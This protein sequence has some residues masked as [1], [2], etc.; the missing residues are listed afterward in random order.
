M[1]M[2][3]GLSEQQ[4]AAIDYMLAAEDRITPAR[5]AMVTREPLEQRRSV[6]RRVGRYQAI[7]MAG[8]VGLGVYRG[9]DAEGVGLTGPQP[10]GVPAR[11]PFLVDDRQVAERELAVGPLLVKDDV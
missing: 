6:Y 4:R 11:R 2:L 3:S 7:C 10:S 8:T 5:W 9:G 1:P